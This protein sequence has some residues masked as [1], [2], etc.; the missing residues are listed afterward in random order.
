MSKST[1][2][3]IEREI[4]CRLDPVL[5]VK[6][7]L[8]ISLH[9]WQKQFLRAKRGASILAL[10]ARQVGK[11]TVA[12][13]GMAHTAVFMPGSLSIVVCPIQR[14]SAE[15]IRKVRDMVI[16]AGAKLKS[17]NVY[18]IE[19][20]NRSRVLAFPGSDESIRGPTVDGWIIVDE[21]ARLKAGIIDA[22]RPMRARC[23]Q[24]RLVMLST[25]W[26]QT[27][28]FWLAWLG[29]DPSWFRLQATVDIY[30]DLLPADFLEVE[31]RHGEDYFNREYLGIPSGGHMSPFT[32]DMYARA[33]HVHVPIVPP[34]PA[35]MPPPAEQA[36]RIANPFQQL[37]P[38][39]GS[40]ELQ[41]E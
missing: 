29:D 27:D 7:V 6:L 5:W 18:G 30:P 31:R 23:P 32:W 10:A 33:I 26:S 41:S 4:A 14:Q 9:E 13:C 17:D 11:T 36:V 38:L 22:L 21:A 15:A 3:N 39:G 12:A 37:N 8:E 40:N 24:T 34:G 19:L 1:A 28:Q 25:A 35:F 2:M 20:D 16:K